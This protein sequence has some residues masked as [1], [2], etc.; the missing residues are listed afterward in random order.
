MPPRATGWAATYPLATFYLLAFAISWAG[1]VPGLAAAH[2]SSFFRNPLWQAS[3]VLCAV[4][5]ALAA[6]LVVRWEG[7]ARPTPWG[8]L[9][10]WRVPGRW[11]AAAVLLPFFVVVSAAAVAHWL[12]PGAGSTSLRGAGLGLFLL[13]SL[14]ANPWEEIGWR[15]FALTRL[16]RR[17][18]AWVA[19]LLVGGLW[20]LWHLPLFS[21]RSG[22]LAMAAIPY[23][24]WFLG[25]LG[26]SLLLA[27]L[28]NRAGSSILIAS[29]LGLTQS[30]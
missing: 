14:L 19:A 25:I 10:R 29:L 26:Q 3:L 15:G 6:G 12:A 2:G 30:M 4:G 18:P 17:Y 23:L 13:L 1:W 11:Y 24:P 8:V 28:F 21:L 27:W 20:G 5:P 7:G 22:P 16:Q 9:F